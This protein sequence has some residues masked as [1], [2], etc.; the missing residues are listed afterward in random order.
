[1]V[2]KKKF[3]KINPSIVKDNN[4][5]EVEVYLKYGIYKSIHE[6]MDMLKKRIAELKK[7]KGIQ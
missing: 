4:G 5:K 3:P 1:M 7:K 2:K 6:E